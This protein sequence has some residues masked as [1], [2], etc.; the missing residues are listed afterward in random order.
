MSEFND[1]V[2]R[3]IQETE[4]AVTLNDTDNGELI[5][6]G[7]AKRD[8]LYSD[9]LRNYV[10]LTQRR[11]NLKEI[12][13]WIF[14]WVMIILTITSCVV[15]YVYIFTNKPSENVTNIIGAFISLITSL[16]A[17]PL[18]IAKYLFNNKEDDNI[19]SIIAKTEKH[20]FSEIEL[21][22]EHFV[23][24]RKTSKRSDT[25]KSKEEKMQESLSFLGNI[26]NDDDS[27]DDE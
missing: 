8:S 24:E 12:H 14:F 5:A 27:I 23:K 17:V 6:K 13:K 26:I 16:I 15:C 19:T 9:L 10:K 1:F 21:L 4:G 20:D 2:R 25:H 7:L 18:I 3:Y 11:N 22:K